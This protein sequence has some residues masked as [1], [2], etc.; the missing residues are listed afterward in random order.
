MNMSADRCSEKGLKKG[1]WTALEVKILTDYVQAHGEG[2][3]RIL[4]KK[5]GEDI[6]YIHIMLLLLYII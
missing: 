4:P 2:R 5:A 3:W 6:F 1:A